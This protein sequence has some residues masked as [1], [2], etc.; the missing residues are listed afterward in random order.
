MKINIGKLEQKIGRLENE[1]RK[2]INE[3]TQFCVEH[4]IFKG[5]V[6]TIDI[7]IGV[8][9]GLESKEFIESLINTIIKRTVYKKNMDIEKIKFIL[10][11]LEKI[12]LDL[13]YGKAYANG[14]T[15]G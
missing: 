4:E 3:I 6:E 15:I 14:V 11:E 8:E 2:L 5:K 9:V 13:E 1:R 7:E 10:I 12:R